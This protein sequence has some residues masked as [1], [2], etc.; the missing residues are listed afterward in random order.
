[1]SAVLAIGGMFDARCKAKH[2]HGLLKQPSMLPCQCS[3]MHGLL[4]NCSW[5]Q[6]TGP[7]K[8]QPWNN[9]KGFAP[10]HCEKLM[11]QRCGPED[12]QAILSQPLQTHG[13]L[14]PCLSSGMLQELFPLLDA[15][16]LQSCRLSCIQQVSERPQEL[17]SRFATRTTLLN[18]FQL[19]HELGSHLPASGIALFSPRNGR[20]SNEV[21]LFE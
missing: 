21:G 18:S 11:E 5:I 3:Y 20:R 4:W 15:L 9:H 12:H 16:M 13:I 2:N 7:S 19:F 14:Q 8:T 6:V 17:C 1:M 10:D